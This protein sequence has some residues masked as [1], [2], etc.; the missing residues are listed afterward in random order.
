MPMPPVD[1]PLNLTTQ[2]VLVF[3]SYAIW[4]IALL[5]AI[6]AG[7]RQRTPFFVLVIMAAAFGGLF[8]PL[9]DEGLMLWFYTPGQWTAYTAFGIPQPWWVYSGYVTLYGTTAAMICHQITKGMTRG[10][11]YRWAGIELA[12]SC[13]F[14]M[15]GINGGA[16]EYWGPHA[17]RVLDYPIVI[18][19]LESAQ[20]ICF[21]VAAAQLRQR[22]TSPLQL[23]GVF[24]LFPATFY[25]A[26]F[27]AG[28]P[29]IVVLHTAQPAPWLI[30]AATLLSIGFALLLIRFAAELLP[31]PAQ[32]ALPL[33]G[34]GRVR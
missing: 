15:I 13:A 18:G 14:E 31:V 34:L 4:A 12:C 25:M 17:F 23:W 32:A 3:G 1:H 16:Y 8:E 29:V 7:L 30:P 28:A 19:I 22:A 20:V 2:A 26:N 9:Y 11:L 5:V 6:I 24:A 21:S 27:G 10:M 33:D